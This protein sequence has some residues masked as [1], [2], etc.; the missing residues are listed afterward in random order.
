MGGQGSGRE[1]GSGKFIGKVSNKVR[2][3]NN[4]TESKKYDCSA[5]LFLNVIWFNRL[6][7][8]LNDNEL[9]DNTTNDFID[10]AI[11]QNKEVFDKFKGE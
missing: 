1:K 5:L 7:E 6:K 9:L 11:S 4:K 8:I 3:G 10:N 2:Y